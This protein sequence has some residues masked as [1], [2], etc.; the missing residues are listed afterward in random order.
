MKIS[1]Q[2]QQ[3][4]EET[5]PRVLDLKYPLNVQIETT[6]GC[7]HSCFYCYNYWRTDSPLKNKM[8]EDNAS[9]LIDIIL[10]DVK[11]FDL[12]ITGGEPLT[13]TKAT[14]KI[15]EKMGNKNRGYTLNT[16]LT[17]L[18]EENI[19]NLLL[20]NKDFTILTSLPHYREEE[21]KKITGRDTLSLFYKNLEKSMKSNLRVVVNMVVHKLNK[22]S[23]YEEGKYLI[24]NFGLKK[25]CATPALKPSFRESGDYFLDNNEIAPV[26]ENL[27]RLKEDYGIEIE[28]LELVPYCLMSN[29]LK[30]E[31]SLRRSCSAGRTTMQINY[32]GDVRSCS[33]SPFIEGNLLTKNF[34]EIWDSLKPYRENEY[35]PEECKECAEVKYCVGG[36]RFVG[37]REGDSLERKDS[38]MVGKIDKFEPIAIPEL[39][40]NKTYSLRLKAYRDE[41]DDM[42][43]IYNG[44]AL[45][46]NKNLL[47]FVLLLKENEGFR[48]NSFSEKFRDKAERIS[49][50]LLLGGFLY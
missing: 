12:T 49:Q 28:T 21:F 13:N 6:E 10:E 4:I 26:L 38:R 19:D 16:N 23:V 29:K 14:L 15:A 36:C 31:I 35:V 32:N 17:L 24:E 1:S 39:D 37:F 11:P 8:T 34:R 20:R 22:D 46:V 30:K 41:G 9:R 50:K 48:L 25:F 40:P 5:T 45:R 27:V 33:H 47:N 44:R 18:D 42:F 43:T 2:S 7:N 3:K